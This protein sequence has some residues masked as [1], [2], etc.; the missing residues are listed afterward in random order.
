MPRSAR[1]FT[2]T[3]G[4]TAHEKPDRPKLRSGKLEAASSLPGKKKRARI[5]DLSPGGNK[6]LREQGRK[7]Y[8]FPR[9]QLAVRGDEVLIVREDVRGKHPYVLGV[10]DL[11][12]LSF[13]KALAQ[14]SKG[15]GT[16]PIADALVRPPAAKVPKPNARTR[17][18]LRGR[19]IAEQDIASSGGAVGLAEVRQIM[20]GVTRQAVTNRVKEGSLLAVPGPSN[21]R[22][23]PFVQF[24]DGGS[25]VRG[26]KEVRAA[27]GTTSGV[28]ILNFLV[29]KEPRLGGRLPIDLLKAGDLDRVLEVARRSGIQGA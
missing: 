3:P 14:L 2:T 6:M 24:V 15:Q 16:P 11:R 25:P 18:L 13:E 27:L 1:R 17:A 21:R 4:R 8:E 26:L 19:L 7:P 22:I 20:N 9:L 10:L 23:Y 12:N 28:A 5:R 29:N